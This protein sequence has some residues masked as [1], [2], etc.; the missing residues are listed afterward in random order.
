MEIRINIEERNIFLSDQ[1][2]QNSVK[3]IIEK[4]IKINNSDDLIEKEIETY[5]LKYERKPINL[6]IDSFGGNIYQCFGL[7]S[8]ME[9]SKTKINT[10]CTGAAMS[11]GFIILICGHK[12]F[13]YKLS[14][15][16]YHQGSTY[17]F[18]TFKEIEESVDENKRLQKIIETIVL[19][20]TSISEK[21]LKEV[22]D[23]KLDWFISAD[24]ALKLNIIDEII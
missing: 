19:E 3:D 1:V 12:R 14:T 9:K 8:V 13:A 16:L 20:K 15:P 4:I 23:K 22:Y 6:Y 7:I 11:A 5:G 24:D 21:R 17:N 10:I 2:T 18:G